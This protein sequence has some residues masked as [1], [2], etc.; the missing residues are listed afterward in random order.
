MTEPDAPKIAESLGRL[1]GAEEQK[2]KASLGEIRASFS[3]PGDKGSHAEDVVRSLLRRYFPANLRVGQGEIVDSF[4]RRSKQTD[5]VIVSD[6]HPFTFEESKAGLFFIE[7][8]MGAGEV[9]SLLT[10]Q[11]LETAVGNSRVFKGLE[12]WFNPHDMVVTTP[13]DRQRYLG[14]PPWFLLAFESDLSL[15]TIHKRLVAESGGTIATN[16]VDAVFALDK[17]FVINFGDGQ[18]GFKMMGTEG[19]PVSGWARSENNILITLLAWL[20]VVMLRVQRSM[21]ILPT[22]LIK[23]WDTAL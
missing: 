18:G 12:A 17:G 15:E 7:G 10:S 8:V 11:E 19:K 20:S 22:Y 3:H 2:L 6:D 13:S 9:K 16:L 21:S 1:F 5:I 14:H 4:G 23:R